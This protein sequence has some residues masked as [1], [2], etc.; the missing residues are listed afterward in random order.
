MAWSIDKEGLLKHRFWILLAA[1]SLL[2]LSALV[3]L[4]ATVGSTVEKEKKAFQAAN[5]TLKTLNEPKNE[6]WV[7]ALQRQDLAVRQ[8]EGGVWQQ[9]WEIQKELMTWPDILETQ[10]RSKY[11]YF[12]QAVDTLDASKFP[13]AY[14]RQLWQVWQLAQPLTEGG[15]GA[16][17]FLGGFENVL[18]LERTFKIRTTQQR[19]C[20]A[21][22]GRPVDQAG[23]TTGGALRQRCRRS[24]PGD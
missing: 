16:V 23:F 19:R 9:C 12:G 8:K 24:L 18:K 22:P 15:N 6:R 20:L 21:G 4:P 5:D 10:W 14:P 7:D 17:Q 13:D 1:S 11:P 2:S 3:L